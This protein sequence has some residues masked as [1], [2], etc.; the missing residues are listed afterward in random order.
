MKNGDRNKKVLHLLIVFSVDRQTDKRPYWT[1]CLSD[2]RQRFISD[3]CERFAL[4]TINSLLTFLPLIWHCNY[5]NYS[6]Y[7]TYNNDS[8]RSS[9][10]MGSCSH[11]SV[12]CGCLPPFGRHL[13]YNHCSAELVQN[14]NKDEL[15]KPSISVFT[16]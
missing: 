8:Q 11:S 9:S 12:F 13:F 5:S 16:C 6:N 4:G 14:I 1:F 15:S 10:R 7:G 2:Q 3:K